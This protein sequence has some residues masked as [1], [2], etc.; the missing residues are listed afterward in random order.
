[1]PLDDFDKIERIALDRMAGGHSEAA[2][3]RAQIATAG[4]ISRDNNG[5][6]FY[7]RFEVVR[8]AA[9]RLT[10]KSPAASAW[11]HVRGLEYGMTFL[12]WADTQGYLTTLEGAAF[13]EDI[14][15]LNFS[16]TEVEFFAGREGSSSVRPPPPSWAR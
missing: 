14:S 6:G 13:G 4:S 16:S 11:A 3:I 8:D 10:T 5:H 7:T 1:M 15:G 12:L 2:A 9:H